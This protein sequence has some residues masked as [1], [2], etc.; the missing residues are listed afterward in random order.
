M[1]GPSTIGKTTYFIKH[2]HF[3]D[4]RIGQD[5]SQAATNGVLLSSW[6][7]P[8]DQSRPR[9]ELGSNADVDVANV[10][11][12]ER[13]VGYA[14]SISGERSCLCTKGWATQN[15][16]CYMSHYYRTKVF[17]KSACERGEKSE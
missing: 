7:R 12:V 9:I 6:Q 1:C 17:A 10:R 13:T 8:R 15:V 2:F 4:H 14:A 16:V 11:I 3:W 5:T